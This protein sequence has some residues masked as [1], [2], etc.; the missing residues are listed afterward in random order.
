M[1]KKRDRKVLFS[2]TS[3]SSSYSKKGQI[4]V[5][6]ILG[7]LLL[8]ALIL[9]LTLKSE[10]FAFKTEEIIPTE[11]GKVENFIITCMDQIGDDALFKI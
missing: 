2:Q 4:T 8:L 9:V 7:I 5:F 10:I 11:K 1:H 3:N 6:I